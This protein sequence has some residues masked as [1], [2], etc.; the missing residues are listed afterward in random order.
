[1]RKLVIKISPTSCDKQWAQ[2]DSG[3]LLQKKTTH[4]EFYAC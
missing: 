1:M 3:S 2:E 4:V